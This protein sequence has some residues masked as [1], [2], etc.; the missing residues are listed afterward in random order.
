MFLAALEQ[1]TDTTILANPKVLALNKQQG[2][3][4]VGNE[5]GYYTTITTET[6]TSQTVESLKTG[7]RLIFRP[8]IS[9]DGYIRM[10]VHPE[11]SAGEVKANGL[12]SKSTT[13]VS[14]N[15]MV[16]DG[17][18][19][20]IGGLFRESSSVG[21][22]QVPLLGNL[23]I[24]GRAFRS[25][26]DHTVREEVIVLLTPHI[27]KDD[28]AM[29][30]LSQEELKRTEQ[31]RVGARRGMMW[32]GRERLAESAYESAKREMAKEHPNRSTAL[33]HLDSALNL[34]PKMLE[35]IEMKQELTGKEVTTTDGSSVRYYVRKAILEDIASPATR[36]ATRP[37]DVTLS[38]INPGAISAPATQPVAAAAPTTQ[39]L[40]TADAGQPTTQPSVADAEILHGYV[41]EVESEVAAAPATQP[42]EPASVVTELP[43]DEVDGQAFDIETK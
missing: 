1:V 19:I 4:F 8:Y 25:Q 43:T 3:V 17:H 9:G 10:E 35:A 32:F 26:R 27:V 15:V 13:E 31:L 36:P 18:T 14:S 20:V 28:I 29:D 23:P 7:T 5:D 12:P 16:K 24:I 34:N 41:E 37:S 38:A 6:T 39:P 22:S 21:R 42:S 2:E 33:W 30:G 40:T 11:D